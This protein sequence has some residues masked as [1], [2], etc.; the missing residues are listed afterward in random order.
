MSVAFPK[1][2]QEYRNAQAPRASPLLAPPAQRIHPM[3]SGYLRWK[4]LPPLAIHFPA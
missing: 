3:T 4:P 1:E 2:S